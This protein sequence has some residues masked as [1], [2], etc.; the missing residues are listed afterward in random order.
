MLNVLCKALDYNA[1]HSALGH[2]QT[3]VPTFT[4]CSYNSLYL[5]SI[6]LLYTAIKFMKEPHTFYQNSSIKC[7]NVLQ[8]KLKPTFHIT[9]FVP[10][11][12][13]LKRFTLLPFSMPSQTIPF[14]VCLFYPARKPLQMFQ[15]C[16]QTLTAE[17]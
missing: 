17:T 12:V 15:Q 13:P 16:L 3:R 7:V 4:F 9:I 2:I 6:A 10:F 8:P 11:R 1:L 14:E 5:N